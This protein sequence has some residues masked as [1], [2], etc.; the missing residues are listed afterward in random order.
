MSTKITF[1]SF[2]SIGWEK[3]TVCDQ[4]ITF[5]DANI[6]KHTD[7]RSMDC[8]THMGSSRRFSSILI[9]LWKRP[10]VV[11]RQ[12]LHGLFGFSSDCGD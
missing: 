4:E 11:P 5:S 7:S 10:V 8:H 12:R 2:D 9:C 1:D 3:H 6:V